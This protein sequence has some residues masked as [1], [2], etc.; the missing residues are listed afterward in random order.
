MKIWK[1]EDIKIGKREGQ[2]LAED[3]QFCATCDGSFG[4]KTNLIF[5]SHEFLLIFG[6]LF[7]AAMPRGT[8]LCHEAMPCHAMGNESVPCQ[9]MPCLGDRVCAMNSSNSQR[10]KT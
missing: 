9:A 4:R 10:E 7:D 5:L 2:N 1:C 8:S 3:S 6:S